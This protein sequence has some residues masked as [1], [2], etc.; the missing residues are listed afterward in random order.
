MI[1]LQEELGPGPDDG[2]T[3][4][5]AVQMCRERCLSDIKEPMAAVERS[6]RGEGKYLQAEDL[7]GLRRSHPRMAKFLGEP[8]TTG[9]A[10]S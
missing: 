10:S 7:A 3:V 1:L 8:A 6:F 4:S 5:G 9:P 2:N